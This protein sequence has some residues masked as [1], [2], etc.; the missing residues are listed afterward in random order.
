MEFLIQQKIIQNKSLEGDIYDKRKKEEELLIQL[1]Q[2]VKLR[3]ERELTDF[4]KKV[5]EPL[6]HFKNGK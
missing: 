1:R 5:Y 4:N 6:Q 2:E 3:E